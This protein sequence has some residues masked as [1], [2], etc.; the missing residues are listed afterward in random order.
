M[1]V[2]IIGGNF[3]WVEGGNPLS[4]KLRISRT[5]LLLSEFWKYSNTIECM[6]FIYVLPKLAD[7][8]PTNEY[9]I[10]TTVKQPI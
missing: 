8:I 2:P 10:I 3:A 7:C 1:A 4:V 6:K 9:Y 5:F